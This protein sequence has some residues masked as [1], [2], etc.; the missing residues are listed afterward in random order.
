MKIYQT[1]YAEYSD[2]YDNFYYIRGL[3]AWELRKL[4]VLAN[5]KYF[6]ANV[7]A[8]AAAQTRDMR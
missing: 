8:D 6:N 2:V 3:V 7:S 4:G 1:E 5:K